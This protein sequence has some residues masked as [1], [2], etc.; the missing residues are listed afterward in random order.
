MNPNNYSYAARFLCGMRYCLLRS[1]C[2]NFKIQSEVS[3]MC[4][5]IKMQ[6][7]P[8]ALICYFYFLLL[9][10]I[11]VEKVKHI[12]HNKKTIDISFLFLLIS[13]IFHFDREFL[14]KWQISTTFFYITRIHPT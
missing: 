2:C 12:V 10:G 8:H 3:S 13:T 6:N 7:K 9:I 14:Y 1:I 4:V 11:L 5:G